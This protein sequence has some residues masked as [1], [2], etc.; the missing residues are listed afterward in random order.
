MVNDFSDSNPIRTVKCYTLSPRPTFYHR[1]CNAAPSAVCRSTT[2]F[3]LSND[4]IKHLHTT[5]AHRLSVFKFEKCLFKIVSIWKM[6]FYFPPCYVRQVIHLAEAL[7][8]TNQ[9][10]FS[11]TSDLETPHGVLTKRIKVESRQYTAACMKSLALNCTTNRN[12]I[13]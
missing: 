7:Y 1:S 4:K 5:P 9:A 3:T 11:G 8:N 10:A 13:R 12:A 6:N 2:S